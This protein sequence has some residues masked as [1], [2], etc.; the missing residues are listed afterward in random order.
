MDTSEEGI[1]VRA[2]QAEAEISEGSAT[3]ELNGCAQR[4]SKHESDVSRVLNS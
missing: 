3:F 2:A 1:D 4:R